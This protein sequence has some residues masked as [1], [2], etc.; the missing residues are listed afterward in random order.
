MRY[1]FLKRTINVYF[2]MIAFEYR[3]PDLEFLK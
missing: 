2:V 1:G 3:S